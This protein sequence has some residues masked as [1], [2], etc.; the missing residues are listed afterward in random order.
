LSLAQ[1]RYQGG[2]TSYLEVITAESA[3]LANERAAVQLAGRRMEAGVA[4]VR[5]LGGG[6]R[7]SDLPSGSAV[8]SR[9]G[10]P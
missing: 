2:I 4:L 10:G 8:L 5:A 1:T 3:A 7:T 6:W 9:S